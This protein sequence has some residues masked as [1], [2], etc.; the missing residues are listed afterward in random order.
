[1]VDP[2]ETKE[3]CYPGASFKPRLIIISSPDERYWGGGEFQKLRGKKTGVFRYFPLWSVAEIQRGWVHFSRNVTLSPRQIAER[4]RQVGGVPRNL[5]A[6]EKV[7]N[8]TLETQ[9][10]AANLITLQQAQDI[11]NGKMNTVGLL[12]NGSPKS[13]V[14]GIALADDD[15]GMYSK[16]KAVPVSTL[17]AENV[18]KRHIQDLWNDM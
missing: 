18:F 12:S 7:Y 6:G 10:G 3:S 9:E 15:G 16:R 17:A 11:V 4:Y 14:V 1:M 13:A 5:I 2:G 8:E